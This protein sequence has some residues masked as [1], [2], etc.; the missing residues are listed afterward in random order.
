MRGRELD[1]AGEVCAAL[2]RVR[3]DI[4][5][6]PALTQRAPEKSR[7]AADRPKTR[8]SGL[9]TITL[10]RDAIDVSDVEQIVDQGQTEAIAGL[11]GASS[12]KLADGN[13]PLADLLEELQQQLDQSG[14]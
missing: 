4:P 6:F 14:T 12:K 5:G 7:S 3:S 10:D 13:R 11:C 1:R 8:T 9:D 2:P